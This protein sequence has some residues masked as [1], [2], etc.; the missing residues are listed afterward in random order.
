MTDR[1]DLEAAYYFFNI[2]PVFS[3][4]SL[5]KLLKSI[6]DIKDIWN[7]SEQE[8]SKLKILDKDKDKLIFKLRKT[9]Y[10]QLKDNI[11]GLDSNILVYTDKNF[12]GNLKELKS[13]PIMI[14]VK[15]NVDLLNNKQIIGI[16]GTRKSS[17]YG[18]EL[19]EKHVED[20][21]HNNIS[22]IT[23]NAFGIDSKVIVSSIEFGSK[24][25]SVL[26]SGINAVTPAKSKDL[27]DQL[28]ANGGC[29][30]S[31]FPPIT[32]AYKS[33][34]PIRAKIIAAL[35]SH[36]II[37]EAPNDSGALLVAKEAFRLKKNI[38]CPTSYCYDTN[39]YGSHQLIESG[40]ATLT[41]NFDN[42][43]QFM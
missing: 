12:P 42:I 28:I 23:G 9:D 34:Y 41:K 43:K 26:A 10:K 20:I 24:C 21:S 31:E 13:P 15:G 16:V 19:V 1:L 22:I 8:I 14:F 6:D 29:Y 38:F 27:L 32:P 5:S 35:A 7:L 11:V 39:F 30:F 18:E 4:A 2:P 36:I 37:I 33:N 3:L 25:I 40:M 17:A